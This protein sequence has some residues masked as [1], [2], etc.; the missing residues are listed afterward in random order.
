MYWKD[1]PACFSA[2][3]CLLSANCIPYLPIFSRSSFKNLDVTD[4]ALVNNRNPNLGS[5]CTSSFLNSRQFGY[6]PFSQF[7]TMKSCYLI[8]RRRPPRLWRLLVFAYPIIVQFKLT[9][10]CP[11]YRSTFDKIVLNSS[12]TTICLDECNKSLTSLH[13]TS[14]F[15]VSSPYGSTPRLREQF[16]INIQAESFPTVHSR[17]EVYMQYELGLTTLLITLL[18]SDLRSSTD[19]CIL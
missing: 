14:P 3:T 18:M 2:L 15:W 13:C 12:F 9:M 10:R 7:S 5:G 16:E 6:K 1:N 8:W 4:I 19:W 17:F 11:L